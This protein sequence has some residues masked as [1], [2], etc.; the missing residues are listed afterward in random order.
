MINKH[1]LEASAQAKIDFTMMKNALTLTHCCK[2]VQQQLLV[3]IGLFIAI[4]ISDAQD[5]SKST[6]ASKDLKE[7]NT[8]MIAR[9]SG[10]VTIYSVPNVPNIKM[11]VSKSP[12]NRLSEERQVAPNTTVATSN[13]L[14]SPPGCIS[15]P[16]NPAN[17]QTGVCPAFTVSWTPVSG[18][19][20]YKVY[21]VVI[22][23]FE[24]LVCKPFN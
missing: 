3:L 9:D 22:T 24:F 15:A 12:T 6:Y 14:V 11:M 17:G 5:L 21:L 18:A 20:G 16:S 2:V 7:I 10:D 4:G 8:A 1:L 23:G 13:A 19:T